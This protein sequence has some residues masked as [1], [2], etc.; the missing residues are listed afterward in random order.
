MSE[1]LTVESAIRLLNR[2]RSVFVDAGIRW[3]TVKSHEVSRNLFVHDAGIKTWGRIEFLKSLG[4]TVIMPDVGF[5]RKKW[6][7]RRPRVAA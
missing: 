5:S 2:N 1:E 4:F 6:S 3:I 7:Y